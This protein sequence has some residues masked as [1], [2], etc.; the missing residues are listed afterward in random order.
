MGEAEEERGC[1]SRQLRR[2]V[3]MRERRWKWQNR[4]RISHGEAKDGGFPAVV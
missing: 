3:S 2:G 1:S 4:G